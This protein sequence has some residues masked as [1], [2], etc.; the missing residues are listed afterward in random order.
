MSDAQVTELIPP[1][2]RAELIRA[3]MLPQDASADELRRLLR[4]LNEDFR[5]KPVSAADAAATGAGCG[6]RRRGR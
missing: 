6:R 1:K 5:D 4:R 3:G 2:A